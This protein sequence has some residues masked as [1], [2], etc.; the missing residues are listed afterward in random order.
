MS[1]NNIEFLSPVGRLVQGDVFKPN[2]TD[3]LGNPLVIK[4]GANAGQPREEYYFAIAI[5]KTDPGFQELYGKILQAA[6]MGYPSFFD[7][8]G[9]LARQLN[10]KLI[11]GDDTNVNQ[12]GKR[13]CDYE[14]F[15]GHWVVRMSSGFAPK[16]FDNT[17]AM[18]QIHEPTAIKRGDYIQVS[19]TIAPNGS[20]NTP[21]PGVFINHNL[22]RLVGYGE[23]ISSGPD[24]QQV[25]S[26]PA[27]S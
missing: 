12:A 19:G 14:G 23:A 1:D 9:N 26:A 5:P 4:H 21:N 8:S 6:K 24:P 7:A 15:P 25:F 17:P 2:K 22:V 11:D 27:R 3:T 13:W 20:G 10:L 16:V 18:N